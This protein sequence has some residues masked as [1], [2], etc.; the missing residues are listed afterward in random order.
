[1]V[2][3]IVQGGSEFAE[4]QLASHVTCL[5]EVKTDS[6]FFCI[7]P[8]G[9]INLEIGGKPLMSGLRGR[10]FAPKLGP[11]IRPNMCENG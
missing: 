10:T 1:M 2:L 7:Y 5:P 3:W 8:W 9:K 4:G 11:H 6:F